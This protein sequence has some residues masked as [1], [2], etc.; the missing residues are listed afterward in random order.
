MPHPTP[1]DPIV[2]LLPSDTERSR[3]ETLLQTLAAWR[4]LFIGRR[5]LDFGSSVGLSSIALIRHGAA[6]VVGVEPNLSRVEQGRTLL[7]EL[8]LD[9]KISLIHTPKTVALPFADGEFAFI[10]ANAVIE[11]IAQPRDSY[12]R[13]LWR[14]LA[15]GGHLMINET[16]NKYWP[17]ELHTTQLWF[18]NWLPRRLAHWRAVRRR[19]FDASRTDWDSSG[20]RGLGYFEMV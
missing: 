8:A 2:P 15:P 6:E 7:A 18:N 5:V 9:A 11:H 1:A 19:R 17:K 13:E 16:P 4:T 14:V 3:Y 12:I 10:L 20:W